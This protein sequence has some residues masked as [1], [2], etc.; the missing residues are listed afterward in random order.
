MDIFLNIFD[1]RPEDNFQILLILMI[2]VWGAGRIFKFLG[3]PPIP[4]E[5]LSGIIVGPA[6]LGLLNSEQIHEEIQ[7]LAEL[8]I[9]FL[10]FHS[11]LD[12]DIHR[13]IKQAKPSILIALGGMLPLLIFSFSFLFFF[14]NWNI[15]TSLFVASIL[16]LNSIPVILSVLK[17]YKLNHSSLGSTT[18]GAVVA[19]EII[20][21]IIISVIISIAQTGNFSSE[22]IL[23]TIL[24]VIGF[25]IISL[26][27]GKKLLP[28]ISP[29]ILNKSGS[30]GFTFALIIALFFGILAEFIGLHMI[31]G[32][33]L[34]G[35][36][37]R[38]EITN[39]EI[40]KKIED[41]FYGLSHSFLGP[42]FFASIG[43]AISFSHVYD[44]IFFIL[45][46]LFFIYFFQ[47][48]G[49]FLAAKL[50]SFSFKDSFLIGTLLT[51]RG[52]T[53]IIVA[54]VGFSTILAF[55]GE[56]IIS[57]KIFTVMII[58]SFLSTIIMPLTVKYLV[59]T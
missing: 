39:E 15:L 29:H 18:L 48:I 57:E 14:M 8:G 27:I 10:M 26:F 32:A 1:W 41:R 24:K 30:K 55:S 36:F 54:Q 43:M 31:L 19:N 45:L 47:T 44:Q 17:K 38:E 22:I 28:I 58:V 2:T 23:L 21:F 12:T 20:L 49:S 11:G 46:F 6:V 16:C 25:F 59:K 50:Q 13:F 51:G 3:L 40:M 9:F 56:S 35:M 53:D 5:I 34:A 7:L 4:G 42:I 37:V 52:S 33:Y